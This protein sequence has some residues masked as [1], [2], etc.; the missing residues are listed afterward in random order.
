MKRKNVA[1]GDEEYKLAKKYARRR[2]QKIGEFL[3][4]LV[5]SYDLKQ[6]KRKSFVLS[7]LLSSAKIESP[8]GRKKCI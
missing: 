1:M 3:S 6:K 4:F 2:K 5:R 8:F 7:G